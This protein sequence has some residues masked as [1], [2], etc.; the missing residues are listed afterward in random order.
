MGGKKK[1]QEREKI[2]RERER[3]VAREVDRKGF[4]WKINRKKTKFNRRR[5]GIEER[6][7]KKKIDCEQKRYGKETG[8]K[9]SDRTMVEEI[10]GE[11]DEIKTQ[12]KKGRK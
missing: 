4:T 9:E 5:E 7:R 8:L 6:E 11:G 3:E 12:E 10:S 1:M 2:E